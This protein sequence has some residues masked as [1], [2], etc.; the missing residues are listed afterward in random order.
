[1]HLRNRL[2]VRQQNGRMTTCRVTSCL[3]HGDTRM[4]QLISI[5]HPAYGLR[6]NRNMQSRAALAAQGSD[7]ASWPVRRGQATKAARQGL[8]GKASELRP[9]GG[10][11]AD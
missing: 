1:M 7:A 9:C 11:E 5:L 10:P 4:G 6:R 8:S 2:W 3:G